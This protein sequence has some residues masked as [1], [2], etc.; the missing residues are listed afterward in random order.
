MVKKATTNQKPTTKAAATKAKTTSVKKKTA[1]SAKKTANTGRKDDSVDE[2][3]R[4]ILDKAKDLGL[5]NNFF[6]KTTFERYR[7]QLNI[8][9]S[10]NQAIEENGPT[11]V[12]EYV[13]GREN[14]V[15][16][17][18][19]GEYNKTATAANGT[20][21]TLLKIMTTVAEDQQK[22]PADLMNE[23]LSC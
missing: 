6:F 4:K 18:A 17:P 7:V 12:K 23:F 3:C 16:N 13:K 10:L 22:K 8:M 5:E 19:I 11:V 15:A 9:E 20:V 21:S 14:L 1:T 2:Q